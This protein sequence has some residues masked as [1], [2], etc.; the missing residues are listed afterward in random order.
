MAQV[1]LGPSQDADF[2]SGRTRVIENGFCEW[3][4]HWLHD[5]S[6][7]LTL[8]GRG[9]I[10]L[11]ERR[12]ESEPG[13]MTL[14][15]PEHPHLFRSEPGWDLVW[16]HFLM[17]PHLTAE[18]HWPEEAPGL[19]HCRLAGADF[20]RGRAALLEASQLDHRRASG[21][22]G[23]DYAL[24]EETLMRGFAG[25]KQSGGDGEWLARAQR[26]LLQGPAE[27]LSVDRAAALCGMSRTKFYAAFKRA[28]GVSPRAWREFQLLR[29]AQFLLQSTSLPVAE[30]ARQLGM[31][32]PFYFSTRFRRFC[33]QP[34]TEYRRNRPEPDK[35]VPGGRGGETV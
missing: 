12:F 20:R 1:T 9:A 3:R 18:L 27:S 6:L 26:L 32:D 5:W 13:E 25:H 2:F 34:P 30:I 24:L 35:P 4:S 29:R 28:A 19:R 10:V 11:G 33:G 15:A 21:W 8:G 31:G 7:I 16:F 23:L 17:R 22:H 14:I